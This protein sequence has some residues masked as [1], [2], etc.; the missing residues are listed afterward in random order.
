MS[1]VLNEQFK[2]LYFADIAWPI[3][4]C[5]YCRGIIYYDTQTVKQDGSSD[6]SLKIDILDTKYPDLAS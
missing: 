5:T 2:K 4:K 3:S 6:E 1:K